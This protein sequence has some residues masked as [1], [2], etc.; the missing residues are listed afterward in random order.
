MKPVLEKAANCRKAT[1]GFRAQR[2]VVPRVCTVLIF[3]SL[4]AVGSSI[5]QSSAQAPHDSAG[6][7]SPESASNVPELTTHEELQTFQVKVNL[8][9]VR[10]V[11]RDAHGNAVGNLKQEDFRLFDDNKPQTITKFTVER[12][13]EGANIAASSPQAPATESPNESAKAP[14]QVHRVA[15][16]IDDV[17]T[18][19]NELMQARNAIET[20]IDSLQPGESVA[21][22]TI[23]GQGTQD[24]TNDQDKLRAALAQLKPRST[25]RGILNDCP[26]ID[27]YLANQVQTYHDP[28]AFEVVL[29]EVIGCQFDGN[30]NPSLLG[31]EE[32]ATREAAD[33]VVRAGDTQLQTTLH[34]L[35]DVIRL[36]AALPGQRTV[37]FLSP[38]FIVAQQ[39][40]QLNDILDRAIRAGVVINTLDVKGV[41]TQSATGSDISQKA[42][43]TTVFGPVILRYQTQSDLAQSD[44]IMQIANATGGTFFHNRNDLAGGVN[45]LSAP[46]E[47]TY[48]LAFTPQ[49][50]KNDGKFHA[51]KVEL[52]QGSGLTLQARKGYSAPAEGN[53]NEEAQREIEDEVFAQNEM[54]ELPVQVQTQFFRSGDDSAHINVLVHVDVRRMAF[55]KSGG[56]NMNELT[57]V[58]ALFDGNANFI[59]AKSTTVQMH[60][61][62]ETLAIKLNSGITVRSNFDANPGSYF[63]RVVARDGQGKLAAQNDVLDI[64]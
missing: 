64:P 13:E 8:V 55:R 19:G 31:A 5:A 2:S 21:I 16:L 34:T 3:T 33:R 29:Q 59:S 23:S 27:Y 54:H 12:R 32:T 17:N 1:R 28:Q 51:L 15:Y 60:I 42:Y 24:F 26:P 10:V 61:K 18:A 20:R 35:G 22:F 6:A 38:G 47:F 37:V 40:G 62:D 53:A 44:P 63:I 14:A 58:A 36:V 57:I 45:R 7:A 49:N 48:L 56:R 50:L 41:F 52:K 30:T 9:E 25:G 43:A 46:P 39:Q 4:L 11:V